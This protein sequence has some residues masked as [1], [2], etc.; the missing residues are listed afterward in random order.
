MLGRV[1]AVGLASS[2]GSLIPAAAAFRASVARPSPAP[3][4]E[5]FVQGEEESGSVAIHA[6][7]ATTF[8]FSGVGR[9]IALLVDALA[10]LATREDLSALEAETGLF[11]ALPDPEERGF[12]TGKD[13]F[14]E[15]PDT[16][17]AR[18]EAL[19]ARVFR[20]AFE[21]LRVPWRG[22]PPRFIHGGNAAFALALAAA[23]EELRH[24]RIR[25]ALVCAV[26][27]L[28]SPATLELLRDQGRLKTQDNST[29]LMPG[30]AAVALLL[31]PASRS[32]QDEKEPPVFLRAVG[33]GKDSHPPEGD[34]PTDARPLAG[35]IVSAMGPLPPG[36]PPPVLITDHDGQ[37]HR[38]YEW[39]MLQLQLVDSD[40]RLGACPGWVPAQSF[41][42]TGAASGAMGAAIA[43]R[44]LQR[45]YA[46]S[47]SVLVLSS[48][49]SGE[50]AAIHLSVGEGGAA[51]G[52]A[53]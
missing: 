46:P 49:D 48:S 51:P 23:G 40:R 18:V 25:G 33:L 17:A 22:I 32:K 52:R 11:V 36:E 50:R 44:S 4:F 15:D 7:L 9:L 1:K 6:P 29:G 28:A 41:G 16:A 20:G 14:H 31:M 30:E 39:G 10:D 34:S 27:S 35:C 45:G 26:D 21:A 2:L 43:F 37:H 38:A 12:T 53:R 8:G 13:S 3:D 42:H 24:R 19:G 47:H 5:H